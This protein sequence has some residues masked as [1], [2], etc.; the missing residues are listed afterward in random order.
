MFNGDTVICEKVIKIECRGVKTIPGKNGRQMGRI[1]S[2]NSTC[3]SATAIPTS[4]YGW[5]W[6]VEI[7]VETLNSSHLLRLPKSSRGDATTLQ[8]MMNAKLSKQRF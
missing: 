5:P 2:V 7:V 3:L 4:K 1:K 6:K 8:S